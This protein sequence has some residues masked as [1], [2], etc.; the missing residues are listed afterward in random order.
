MRRAAGI[1]LIL[2]GLTA[3]SP[4]T[5]ADSYPQ[6]QEELNQA[7]RS[8]DWRLETGAYLLPASHATFKLRSGFAL[9][10][11]ADARRYSW[12]A[13]GVEFPDTEIVLS[14]DT[15]SSKADVY[16]EWHDEGYVSDKDWADV[17]ADELLQQYRDGTEASN[18]ERVANGMAAMEV[19]DWLQPPEY[20]E[21]TRTVTYAI[22]LKDTDG[23]WANAMALRLGR[24]GYAQ[25]T[26]AGP[27]G[28]F[29]T[30][31]NRPA[32]L[33]QALS[34]Y[35]FDKGYRYGDFQEGDRVAAFGIGGMIA[36][37]LGAKF[38][39]GLIALLIGSLVAG[40]KI[41]IPSVLV[42]GGAIAKFARKLF[43]GTSAES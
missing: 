18:E 5:L 43:G 26:W 4:A 2:L 9:L 3:A 29:Q 38:G 40:K 1:A 6:T 8:L 35:S 23:S 42:A 12:L 20:D 17:D 39:K 25:F 33:K 10:Q 19:V 41:L 16:I 22:E 14:Y 24:S 21:A 11:G 7:Y 27:I 31:G 30:Q 36:V 34:S 28:T 37:A 15:A 13:S 32:L